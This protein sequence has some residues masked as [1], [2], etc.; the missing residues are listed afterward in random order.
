MSHS[1]KIYAYNE[2]GHTIT[3]FSITH[4]W[5]GHTKTLTG[6]DLASGQWFPASVEDKTGYGPQRDWYTILV[7]IDTIGDKATDFYC[8]SSQAHK[9]VGIVFKDKDLDCR[10]YKQSNPKGH[11]AATSCNDK[12]YR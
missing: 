6:T 7:H 1:L 2:T 9:S 5:D 12:S 11:D 8:D 10:Y 3:S 4:S